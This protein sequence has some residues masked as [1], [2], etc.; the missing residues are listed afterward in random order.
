MRR[1]NRFLRFRWLLAGFALFAAIPALAAFAHAAPPETARSKAAVARNTGALSDAL[2]ERGLALGRPVHLQITKKPARLTAFVQAESGRFV[3]FRSW[4]I[5]AVSGGLGTK[6]REGDMKAPEGVYLVGPEAMNPW[7]S[8]HLSFNLGYPNALDRL[9]GRTGGALMVHGD[10]VS[11]GCYAMTDPAIEEIWTLMV[12]A[13]DGGQEAVSVH[14]FPF[15]MTE[16]A[17]QRHRGHRDSRLWQDL[18]PVWA[19]FH[20]TGRVPEVRT[21][22]GRYRL[23]HQ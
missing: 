16:T 20:E 17:L 13:F 6:R 10:C 3:R 19:A 8:F 14:I 21:G 23:A 7:S 15:E 11:A 12:A 18:A 4:P 2:A 9:H 1:R 22:S 5:C